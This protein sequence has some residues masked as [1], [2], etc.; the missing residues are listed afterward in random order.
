MRIFIRGAVARFPEFRFTHPVDWTI[1]EGENWAVVGPNG[2]GKSLLTDLL[3]GRIVLREGETGHR[4]AGDTAL[5]SRT[6]DL[7]PGHLLARGLPGRVQPAAM[8]R[9]GRRTVAYG[10]LAAV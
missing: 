5:Q 6:L 9:L 7:L 1:G 8:E 3:R 10:R 2:A 4:C